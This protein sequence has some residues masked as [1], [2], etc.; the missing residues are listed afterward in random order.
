MPHGLSLSWDK[1]DCPGE[2]DSCPIGAPWGLN[3][4]PWSRENVCSP[5]PPF[6]PIDK[7]R[8]WLSFF[9]VAQ[10]LD[11]P[12]YSL[13]GLRGMSLGLGLSKSWLEQLSTCVF[14]WGASSSALIIFPPQ[15]LCCLNSAPDFSA[16]ETAVSTTSMVSW[17]RKWP[18]SANWRC[19]VHFGIFETGFPMKPN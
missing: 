15:P 5:S 4:L 14:S 18:G 8:E 6:L 1:S 9:Y 10:V 7:F 3:A 12:V 11:G 2:I 19:F 16:T 17:R 13:R